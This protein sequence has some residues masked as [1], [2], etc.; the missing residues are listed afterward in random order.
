MSDDWRVQIDVVEDVAP[1]LLADIEAAA[2]KDLGGGLDARFPVSHAGEHI[3]IYTDAEPEARRVIEELGPVLA[4]HGLAG[5]VS[6]WRWHPIEERWEDGAKPLPQTEAE[7][8]R[9]HARRQGLEARRSRETGIAEWEVRITLPTR[10]AARELTE[11][12][13]DEGIPTTRGWRHVMV[14]AVNED[15][16]R[17][18]AERLRGEAP[19]GSHLHVEPSGGDAWRIMHPFAVFGGLGG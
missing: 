17:E 18:L 12:L 8:E 7:L 6:V 5:A 11:R 2:P 13:E 9:E 10:E 1:A 3:F 19:D 16:A 14:G 4:T 15:A